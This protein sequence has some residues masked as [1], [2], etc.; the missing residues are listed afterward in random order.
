MKRRRPRGRSPHARRRLA[1][2]LLAAGAALGGFGGALRA[3]DAESAAALAIV[4]GI[5]VVLAGA[6][7]EALAA[8]RFLQAL[9]ASARRRALVLACCGFIAAIGGCVLASTAFDADAPWPL[10]GWALATLVGGIGAA[11]GGIG[12][13]AAF[14]GGDYAAR[15]I[16]RLSD[17]DW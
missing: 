7:V 12:S 6:A 9:P 10:A 14:H 4:T 1:L 13:L 15:R 2:G 3:A 17:E 8:Q 5:L 16:E 11:L